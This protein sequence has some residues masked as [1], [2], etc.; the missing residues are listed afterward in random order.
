[1][2]GRWLHEVQERGGRR[3]NAVVSR[4]LRLAATLHR[5]GGRA[6]LFKL[7]RV[8]SGGIL[9]HSLQN[10]GVNEETRPAVHELLHRRLT[11]E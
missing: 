3:P 4:R 7:S 9:R 1:M 6:H 8:R 2:P 5:G 10:V 11:I